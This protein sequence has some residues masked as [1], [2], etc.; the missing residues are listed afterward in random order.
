M[1]AK[2]EHIG[3]EPG[4]TTPDVWSGLPFDLRPLRYVMAAAEYMSLQGA[5]DALDLDRTTVSKAVRDFEDRIGVGLFERGSYGVRLTDAGARLVDEIVPA[6]TQIDYAIRFAAAAGRVETGTVRIG[7]IS[8]LAGG[9]MRQLV[10]SYR[11]EH[12]GVAIEIHD[13]A[14]RDHLRA[15]RSRQIDLAFLTAVEDAAGCD[16]SELWSERVYVAMSST[17]ALARED[18]LDWPDLRNEVVIISRHASGP[19]VY[20]Y[21]VRRCAGRNGYPAVAYYEAGQETLMHMVALGGE[22]TLVAEAWRE[23][24]IP[25]LTLVPLVADGD[26]VPF[27]AVWSPANDNPSLRRFISFAQAFAANRP[28]RIATP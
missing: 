14:R 4:T 8:T 2:D 6:L 21:V 10:H 11:R 23:M 24:P 28:R 9:F 5:A 7:I 18:A 27:S 25:G 1:T 12:P 16:V 15:I 26:V 22:I 3:P 13:G 19:D 17:H 20:D